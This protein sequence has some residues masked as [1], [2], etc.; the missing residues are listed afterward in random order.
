MSVQQPEF[1]RPVRLDTL[2][3]TAKSITI[4]ADEAERAALARRFDLAGITRLW[5][6]LALTRNGEAVTATG[7]MEAEVTQSCV[8]TGAPLEASIDE[9]FTI[10]F[11]PAPA[12][13]TPDEE[14][15]LSEAEC[16]VVFYDGAALDVGE[17]VA[18]TLSLSL[19]PWPRAPGAE[20]ALR[21]AGVKSEDEAKNESSPFAKL[22]GLKKS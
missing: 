7:H 10:L 14:V 9:D 3:G 11:R 6:T 15:E 18:E 16:D 4:E 17:A 13:G 22:A 5:A 1:S 20:D 21:A 2:P 19:D 8:A 12:D